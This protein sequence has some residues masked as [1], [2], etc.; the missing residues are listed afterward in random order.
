MAD[1]APAVVELRRAGPAGPRRSP[2]SGTLDLDLAAPRRGTSSG[3]PA[4]HRLVAPQLQR[5]EV[6][7]QAI[8]LLGPAAV[9]HLQQRR[10]VDPV[11]DHA[12]RPSTVTVPCGRATGRPA[13]ANIASTVASKTDR[14][15]HSGRSSLSTRPSP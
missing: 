5:D 3:R 9:E 8:D 1:A 14:P 13:S 10:A 11:Q 4:D 6:A 15:F 2:T 12:A 7:G